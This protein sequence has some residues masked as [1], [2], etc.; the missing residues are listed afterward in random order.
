MSSVRK[1]I[2]YSLSQNYLMLVLQ[3]VTSMV[4]A[5][6]LRP[7]EVGIFSVAAA[8]SGLATVVRDFGVAEYLIQEVNLTSDKL[9]AALTVNIIVSWMMAFL[10]F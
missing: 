9:R 6:I 10:M 4:L 7:A 8:L 3:L 2:L 5:R 1:S